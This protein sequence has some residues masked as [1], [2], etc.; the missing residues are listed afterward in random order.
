[1]KGC[2][3]F[4]DSEDKYLF[5]SGHHDGR[6]TVIHLNL[7]DSIGDITAG[8]YHKGLDSVAERIFRSHMN[9]YRMTPD[10]QFIMVVDLGIDQV[11]AYRLSE[12]DKELIPANTVPYDLESASRHF[13]FSPG[14]RFAYL[15]YEARNV[16][17]V[18][19]YEAG[20]KAPVIE[21]I[22]TVS[23]TGERES[24]LTTACVVRFSGGAKYPLCGSTGDDMVGAYKK[25][26]KTGMLE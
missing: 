2:H 4:T 15:M 22:Q 13:I 10:R 12:N 18:Y 24:Q 26:E 25:D 7:D 23:T 21:E 9:C 5:I 8:V 6:A 20:K 19:T 14:G 16:I 3:L 11:K 17:D 1:M